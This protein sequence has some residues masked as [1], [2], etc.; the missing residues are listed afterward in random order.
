MKKSKYVLVA[1]LAVLMV[2]PLVGC[3]Q[4]K[5]EKQAQEAKQQAIAEIK[6]MPLQDAMNKLKEKN[7]TVTYYHK[8]SNGQEQVV[9]QDPHSMTGDDIANWIVSDVQGEKVY[10]DTKGHAEKMQKQAEDQKWLEAK[11]DTGHAWVAVQKYGEEKYGK[12]FQA[13]YLA[14]QIAV[15]PV[16]QTTWF[17]KTTADV[18]TANGKVTKTL[19]AK[20]TGVNEAPQVVDFKLY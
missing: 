3:G 17:L 6:G 9:G 19:E 2:V 20:V 4:S 8:P 11:L 14:N 1:L 15:E 16:D 10:I 13:H 12:D 18:P 7:I 5:E